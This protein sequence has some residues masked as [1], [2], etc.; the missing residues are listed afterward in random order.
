[1][2]VLFKLASA[3]KYCF[4]VDR[5]E[6]FNCCIPFTTLMFELYINIVFSYHGLRVYLVVD[7]NFKKHK[8]MQL[9]CFCANYYQY[10]HEYFTI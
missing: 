4:D 9:A 7:N 8:N 3:L 5:F 6:N 10:I 1:M 2:A